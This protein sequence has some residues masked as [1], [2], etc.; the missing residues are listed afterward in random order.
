MLT[1]LHLVFRD[2]LTL[3]YG[4]GSLLSTAPEVARQLSGRLTPPRLAALVDCVERLQEDM[5]RNMN[6]TLFL[7]RL[8]ACLR[9]AAGY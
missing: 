8:C 9:Q 2:A 5:T 6:N 3:C 7:T 1:G 4:G